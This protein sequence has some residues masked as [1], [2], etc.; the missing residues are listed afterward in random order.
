MP[1]KLGFQVIVYALDALGIADTVTTA[2]WITI[3][4]STLAER[5][6]DRFGDGLA[7]LSIT[8]RFAQYAQF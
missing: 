4:S 6:A 3:T 2:R 7:K 8:A 1:Y 5:Q